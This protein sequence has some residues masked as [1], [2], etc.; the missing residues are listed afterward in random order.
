MERRLA[1]TELDI[2][3]RPGC[4]EL[5]SRREAAAMLPGFQRVDRRVGRGECEAGNGQDGRRFQ[6]DGAA[7]RVPQEPGGARRGREPGYQTEQGVSATPV[8]AG[9]KR[10]AEERRQAGIEKA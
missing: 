8:H 10:G 3:E 1:L 9:P 4:G 5:L 6:L 2:E 7:A